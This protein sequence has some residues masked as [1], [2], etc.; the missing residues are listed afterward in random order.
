MTKQERTEQYVSYFRDQL[1]SIDSLQ[2]RLHKKILLVIILDSL[3]RARY[4]LSTK[5]KKRFLKMI[6]EHAVWEHANRVSV[7]QVSL[8]LTPQ[9]SPSLREYVTTFHAKWPEWKMPGLEADPLISDIEQLAST[10]EEKKLLEEC[11]HSNLLYVYRNHLVHEFREPGHALEMDQRDISPYYHSLTNLSAETQ[12][13]ETWELVYPLGFFK[14]LVSNSLTT[15]HNYL[16]AY[17]LD[18]YSYYA[19]GTQWKNKI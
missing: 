15:L 1:S 17:D 5:V 18:P 7:Y 6:N 9:M 8:S 13:K 14:Q 11:T 16:L 4:P 3:S 12:N 2:T 19:F 10:Q